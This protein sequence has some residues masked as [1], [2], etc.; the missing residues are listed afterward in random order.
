MA[1]GSTTCAYDG[2][3]GVDLGFVAQSFRQLLD[4]VLP[5]L[6]SSRIDVLF[7]SFRIYGIVVANPVQSSPIFAIDLLD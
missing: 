1:H 7:P 2:I 3:N 4:Q 6:A 5:K